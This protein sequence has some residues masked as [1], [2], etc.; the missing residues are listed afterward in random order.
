[1]LYYSILILVRTFY[2]PCIWISIIHALVDGISQWYTHF[3]IILLA[4]CE[5]KASGR[6][7]CLHLCA[8]VTWECVSMT[9]WNLNY[10]VNRK[11][12]SVLKFSENY[13]FQSDYKKQSLPLL[14]ACLFVDCGDVKIYNYAA[15]N[16]RMCGRIS[17]SSLIQPANIL[18]VA[19]SIPCHSP[20]THKHIHTHTFRRSQANKMDIF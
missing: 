13:V 3:I 20:W 11:K 17:Y 1:M 2:S 18:A 7:Y 19:D 8:Y 6:L 14:T 4:V 9:M 15:T 10:K 12:W 5:C 16:R